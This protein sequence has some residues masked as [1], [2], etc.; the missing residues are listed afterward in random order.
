VQ[1]DTVDELLWLNTLTKLRTLTLTGQADD[2]RLDWLSLRH[3]VVV[4]K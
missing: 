2:P 3:D 1:G 4:R